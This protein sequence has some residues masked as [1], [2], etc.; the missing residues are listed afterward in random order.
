MV[1]S[2]ALEAASKHEIVN[3]SE[4]PREPDDPVEAGVDCG[5]LE[6]V[7]AASEIYSPCS[8]KLTLLESCF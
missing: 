1:T 2:Q 8:G 4:D 6:S 7:K 3:G 5:A